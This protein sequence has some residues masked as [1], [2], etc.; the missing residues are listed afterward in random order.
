[1]LKKEDVLKVSKL[2]RLSISDAEATEYGE[3]F[4]KILEY[5]NALSAVN[6][7]NV[8]PTTTPIP[9]ELYLREDAVTQKNT[10]EDIIANAPE[11]GGNLFKV[12]PVV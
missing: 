3:Q 12:P 6:T 2:A 5:F 8:K 10:V 1:M 9:I 7:D 4:Q 11:L